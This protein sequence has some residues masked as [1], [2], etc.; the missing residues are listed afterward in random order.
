MYSKE[1]RERERE[2]Q[3]RGLKRGERIFFHFQMCLEVSP[4]KKKSF[5]RLNGPVI[6]GFFKGDNCHFFFLFLFS[7]AFKE[8]SFLDPLM[9]R[10]N[11]GKSWVR[12]GSFFQEKN[13]RIS[14]FFLVGE[15]GMS[16]TQKRR[17]AL[18]KRKISALSDL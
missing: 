2:T 1:R 15:G 7:E 4:P 6:W 5:W 17:D 18:K 11:V 13:V 8:V 3:K 9:N 12:K 14:F 16:S 10:S